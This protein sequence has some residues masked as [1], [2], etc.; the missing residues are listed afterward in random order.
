M[1]S[2]GVF[3][4]SFITLIK[5]MLKSAHALYRARRVV[6]NSGQNKLLSDYQGKVLRM[7]NITSQCGFELQYQGLE[8][9]YRHY[10]EDKPESPASDIEQLL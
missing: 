4:G 10:R 3:C 6:K 7:M 2:T 9:L 8:M 1:L 5:T